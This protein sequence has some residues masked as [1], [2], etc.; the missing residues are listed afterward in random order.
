MEPVVWGWVL[1]TNRY[2]L[3]DA[4]PAI[5]FQPILYFVLWGAAIRLALSPALPPNFSE[6]TTSQI[7]YDVWLIQGI[8][9]PLLALAAWF[10]IEKCSGL[11]RFAGMWL[12]L[13]A[14]MGML[15]VV[16]AFHVADMWDRAG[17]GDYY[18]GEAHIYTR[19]GWAAIMLFLVAV[20]IRDVWTI[21][22]TETLARRIRVEAK[23]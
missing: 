18:R 1:R 21:T 12:R 10:L 15:F 13:S 19:Y 16:G 2:L 20:V 23:G 22:I 14:D 3:S 4:W 8:S 5:R 17:H 11:T 6:I 7:F 9:Y